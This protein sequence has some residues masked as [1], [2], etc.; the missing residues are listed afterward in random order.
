MV[1]RVNRGFENCSCNYIYIHT[2]GYINIGMNVH[3]GGYIQ[4][5]TVYIYTYSMYCFD[6]V[7]IGM[8]VT[9]SIVVAYVSCCERFE[10]LC[11]VEKV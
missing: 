6:V 9:I 7:N 2:D 11:G 8:F 10:L 5:Y 3:K 4:I 1:L